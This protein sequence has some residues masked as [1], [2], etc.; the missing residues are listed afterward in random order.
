MTSNN[1]PI[2][3]FIDSIFNRSISDIVGS[4]FMSTSPSVNGY[5]NK[6]GYLLQLAAPGLSKQ[7]FN[8]SIEKS[9]L[10]I[11]SEV[12]KELPKDVKFTRREFNYGT[13]T[14]SFTL[15]NKVDVQGIEAKYENGILSIHLPK[16]E[17]AKDKGPQHIKIK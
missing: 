5:E 3:R 16:K 7:D 12:S 14:R 9:K 15:D 13:F 1:F 2:E 11:S 17:E 10:I 6:D 4:D 8:I